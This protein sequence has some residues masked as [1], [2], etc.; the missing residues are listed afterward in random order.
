[1]SSTK[2]VYLVSGANR[3][4]GF[5]LVST[6]AQRPNAVVFAGARDVSKAD[7]LNALA[8][9][10]SNVHVVKLT[11]GD[12]EDNKAA[13][14]E[15]QKIAGQLDVVVANA[16]IS[17]YYGPL[18]ST[19]I[20][21]LHDHFE[22]NTFAPVV[23]FQAVHPLLS[24]SPSGAPQFH[25]ISTGA[26]SISQYFPIQ[27]GAYGGSKAAA[28]F[29]VQTIHTEHASEGFISSAI[30]PGWV[31]TDMGNQGAAANGMPAAPVTV[32]DSVDGILAIVDGA[33]REKSSGK[34]FN[35]VVRSGNPWDIPTAEI[36]W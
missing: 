26:A 5:G 2:T 4:I 19:P 6:L 34:F 31:Q 17:K 13:V 24:K 27:A 3:G 32:Q 23:L 8:K 16:G 36:P 21:E 9:E 29:M 22:I 1:M 28:N 18:V 35:A 7:A 12:A 33:T 14:A 11:S 15:I 25:I 10:K 20:S 30:N